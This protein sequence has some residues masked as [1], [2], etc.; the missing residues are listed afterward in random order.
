M[1]DDL[2]D[3]ILA[4]AGG[5]TNTKQVKIPKQT[6]KR[7]K[8]VVADDSDD[9]GSGGF[10]NGSESEQ[11]EGMSDTEWEEVKSWN[12]KDLMGNEQDRKK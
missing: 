6:P 3:E 4:L 8:K 10:E 7:K 5:N 1:D 11:E 9:W 2:D 12:P